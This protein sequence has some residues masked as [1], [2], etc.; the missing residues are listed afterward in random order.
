MAKIEHFSWKIAVKEVKET[1]C[2]YANIRSFKHARPANLVWE[3]ISKAN[4]YGIKTKKKKIDENSEE[5]VSCYTE[6]D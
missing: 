2:F 5:F 6:V 4:Q 3:K 1:S